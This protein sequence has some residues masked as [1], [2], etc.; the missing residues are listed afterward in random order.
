M[1]AHR[2]SARQFIARPIDEVFAFFAR[3][4][5]LGRITPA[6]MGFEF[7]TEDREMRE[8]LEIRYRIRPL[9]GIPMTWTTRIGAYDPPHR[10]E[11]IQLG[12]PYRRWEHT[13]TFEAVPGGTIVND[14][15]TYEVPLGPLGDLANRLVVRGELERIFRHRAE[16]IRT[17]FA[18]A[19]EPTGRTVAVAG[20]TGFVGGA[21]ATELHRR[22][23]AVRV[24]SHRGESARG[25]LPDAIE[26]HP[27]D[28]QTGDGLVDALRGVD[29]L[30]IA[31]AFKNSPIEAPRKHQTFVEVD[32]EGTE[33]L[34]AAAR[35]AGVQRVV[36]I[37]GA[38]AAPDAK[39]HWFRAKWRAEEAV[40]GS[41]LTWTIIRPTWIFGPRDVSLNRFVGFARRLFSVPMTN[42]GSQL[43]A[44]VFVDDAAALAADSLV[45]DAAVNQVFE[46]GGPETLKMREIIATALRVAGL[47]RPIIPGPTPLIKLAAIPL[48]WL[49]TPLLTP[50]A[51]D[52]I[53]QPATVDLGP[54]LERM[55]RRLTPLEEGLATYLAPP[56]G[57]ARLA[58]DGRPAAL[59][60]PRS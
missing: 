26:I 4:E 54:L 17:V 8:G 40:R 20:G 30:V 41:G 52:F 13:H 14:E 48:S 19:G 37:S 25:G 49:P 60:A 27:T 7:L 45:A 32:A 35:E 53:N 51:V 38:G 42:A 22:G 21:I 18:A 15:I 16:T 57:D 46:L 23:D 55:P 36:Y 6:S 34:I 3:P 2:L 50:A 11:D 58:F 12:G 39:R 28:V 1:T 47:R 5:N 10:F 59:P 29:A 9:L 56:E 31:L 44:P 24:L 33:R 43:L